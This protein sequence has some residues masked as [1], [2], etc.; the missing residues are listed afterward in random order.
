MGVD[1]MCL[2]GNFPSSGQLMVDGIAVN[3]SADG[4]GR[5]K[6]S[7]G[8]RLARFRDETHFLGALDLG[9]AAV[10]NDQLH[11]PITEGFD[12][13]LD[14]PQP[15]GLPGKVGINSGIAHIA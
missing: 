3:A 5:L 8:V 1:R 4:G 7:G 14:H 15:F 6:I 11:D 2:H 9:D 13:L 12:L 10:V